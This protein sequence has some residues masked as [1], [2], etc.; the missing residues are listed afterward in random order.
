[1][2]PFGDLLLP[3]KW[4]V[5]AV[6]GGEDRGEQTGSRFAALQH[7]GKLGDDGSALRGVDP[8]KALADDFVAHIA[9]RL[10]IELLGDDFIDQAIRFRLGLHFFRHQHH[11]HSGQRVE[12]FIG[13]AALLLALARWLHGLL[14]FSLQGGE[15]VAG[16]FGLFCFSALQSEQKLVRIHLLA[17]SPKHPPH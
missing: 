8:R 15:G 1:M 3:I 11:L 6:F 17:A 16:G 5:I 4:Q 10:V 7:G 14:G 12:Q 2:P 9:R 13:D